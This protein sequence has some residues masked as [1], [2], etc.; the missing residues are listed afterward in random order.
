MVGGMVVAR[1]EVYIVVSRVACITMP[2]PSAFVKK[3]K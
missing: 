3:R 1:Q 2:L